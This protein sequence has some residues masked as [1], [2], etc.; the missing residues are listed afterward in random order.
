MGY[1]VI[2]WGLGYTGE[3]SA[4]YILDNHGLELV[5]A[6]CFSDNKHGADIGELVGREKIGIAAT[7]N[8]QDILAIE[9]DC[10]VYMPRDT[11]VDP[12]LP[13]SPSAVLVDEIEALLLSGKN[14]I[15]SICCGTHWRHLANGNALKE[16]LERACAKTGTSIHYSGFD[17]GWASSDIVLSA[18]SVIGNIEQT[19]SWEIVD[20]SNYPVVDTLRIMGFGMPYDGPDEQAHQLI[21]TMWGG[22]VHLLADAFGVEIEDITVES[23]AYLAPEA[24]S[25]AGGL[26]VEKGTMAAK[27]FTLSGYVDGK[28]R[29]Q[30]C[31]VN[32]IG[33]EVAP[34]WPTVGTDGGYR[35]EID[36][37][38]PFRGDFP[39]GLP[40]GTGASFSDA[41]TMTAGRCVN[42]V[43]AV[44]NAKPG[45][46]TIL[47]LRDLY[48]KYTLAK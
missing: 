21:K 5:G 9:A 8:M 41:M 31:H 43:E 40:G 29:F 6:K 39:M 10:V 42:L 46:V 26:H 35:V 1:K 38:P 7:A 44:I 14:V 13:D 48:G 19:R 11:L 12:T 33:N 17:P 32:R 37:F 22:C 25:A 23:D 3:H 18:S 28:A 27:R 24:F 36:G 16:R 15:T 34:D 20:Y 2:Q 45:Y 47:S 30:V 4:R